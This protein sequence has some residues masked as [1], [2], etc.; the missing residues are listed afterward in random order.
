MNI[1]TKLLKKYSKLIISLGVIFALFWFARLPALSSNQRNAI[2]SRFDFTGFPLPELANQSYR[3]ERQVNPSLAH[4]SG[5][6][7]AV[8]AS[9]ALNDLDGDGLSNDVCYVE[10]RS[11]RVIVAPVPTTKQRYQAFTLDVT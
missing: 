1:I 8:G 4:H 5:W 6:I 9:V 10:T 2:A 7:S 11:D 3:L